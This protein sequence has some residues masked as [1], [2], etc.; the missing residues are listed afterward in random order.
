MS[1]KRLVL[2]GGG[3]SH[4][5]V[6]RRFGAAPVPQ[7]ELVL[8]DPSREFAYSGMLP[9]WIAGHYTRHECHVDLEALAR[10]ARCRFVV[11]SCRTLD[12]DARVVSCEDGTT[13]PYDVVSVDTGAGSP[14]QDTSGAL[15]NA[16]PVRPI[17]PFVARWDE[18]RQRTADGQGPRTIAVVGAGAAGVEL[19]LAMQYRL[20]RLAPESTIAFHLVGDAQTILEG[21]NPRVRAIFLRVLEER[22]VAVHLG[23]AVDRVEPGRLWLAGGGSV[24]ADAIVWATGAAASSWPKRA[25]LAVDDRGFILVDQRLQSVSHPLV[26]ASGD[27]ASIEDQ[28]RP[29]NGVYAVR[30]GPPLAANL[31]RALSGRALARWTPQR[32]ALALIST[33]DRYAVASRGP[34]ALEGARVWRWK[35]WIDR[36]FIRRYRMPLA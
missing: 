33:G 30:A 18:I 31:R 10:V 4:I 36:R 12:L 35:D 1:L 7:T 28:P 24:D 19:S 21:H 11:S 5:E 14:A 29:K 3:H 20:Q 17:E 32:H 8:A 2:L 25:G 6:L 27:V 15:N 26:F 16:L 23:R 9:G 34:L 22:S 13:L